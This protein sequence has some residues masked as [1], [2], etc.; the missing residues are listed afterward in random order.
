MLDA[1]CYERHGRKKIKSKVIMRIYR[2]ERSRTVVLPQLPRRSRKSGAGTK[3]EYGL[4]GLQDLS[5]CLAAL[6]LRCSSNQ[7]N[8]Q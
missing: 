5:S 3:Q 2:Q 7:A 1:G 6:L 4:Q 8:D